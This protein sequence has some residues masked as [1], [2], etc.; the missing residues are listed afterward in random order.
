MNVLRLFDGLNAKNVYGHL[1]PCVRS[2]FLLNM[3]LLHAN[4][5]VQAVAKEATIRL[6]PSTGTLSNEPEKFWESMIA[7]L[8]LH[9][10]Y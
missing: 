9:M 5:T 4:L 3:M 8:E 6:P 1:C 10:V 2:D 7:H